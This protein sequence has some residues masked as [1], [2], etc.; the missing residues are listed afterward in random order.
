M[1]LLSICV[2]NVRK[3]LRVLLQV[4]G[5]KKMSKGSKI[6]LIFLFGGTIHFILTGN[7]NAWTFPLAGIFL[8]ILWDL[9]EPRSSNRKAMK[10]E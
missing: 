5:G 4:R 10:D 9:A 6:F 2:Q 3:R 8:G 7:P 1:E